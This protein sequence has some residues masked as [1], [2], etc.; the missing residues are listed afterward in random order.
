M[1]EGADGVRVVGDALWDLQIERWAQRVEV[2]IDVVAPSGMPAVTSWYLLVEPR[3]PWGGIWIFPA[4]VGGIEWTYEHQNHNGPGSKG[5]P[6]RAGDVCVREAGFSLKRGVEDDDPKGDPGRLLWYVGRLREWIQRAAAGSLVASGD[7]F[8]LP[9]CAMATGEVV[10]FSEDAQTFEAWSSVRDQSGLVELVPLDRPF[11]KAVRRFQSVAGEVLVAP[12]W[13]VAVEAARAPELGAW[14]RLPRLPLEHCYTVPT[15]WGELFKVMVDQG[16]SPERLLQP[17]LSKLRDRKAHLLVLGFPIPRTFG[18]PNER[19]H[20]LPMLLKEISAGS[21]KGFRNHDAGH[22]QRDLRLQFAPGKEIHWLEGRNWA[23][24]ELATRG[25]LSPELRSKR[26]LLI[27]A[28]ALGSAVAELLV[29]GGVHKLHIVDQDI[30]QAGNLARHTLS[31]SDVGWGKSAAVA[32]RLNLLSPHAKVVAIARRFPGFTETEVEATR[33]CDLV[34]DC[35]G[36]DDVLQALADEQRLI[37]TEFASFSMGRGALRLYVY[38]CHGRAFQAEKFRRAIGP[39][40]A[41]DLAEHPDGSMPWEAIGCWHP[42]FP[43]TA[44]DVWQFATMAVRD[45]D[46]SRP[47]EGIVSG[48]RVYDRPT[49]LPTQ[50]QP[51]EAPDV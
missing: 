21:I 27:G 1:L 45:L 46:S 20:W 3:Y 42:V 37:A 29:R 30:M 48:L 41:S 2:A 38:R 23:A 14:I 36:E 28:G 32:A 17:A 44:V 24:L 43:A 10:G 8:E 49:G 50:G 51:K 4:K 9:Q 22:W 31:L 25:A 40:L 7:P 34:I 19:Y 5:R 26:V 15:R 11:P 16:L 12:S 13:G 18:G 6:W 35:T 33:A 39:F 47:L